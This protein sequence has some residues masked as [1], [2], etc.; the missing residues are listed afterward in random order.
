MIQLVRNAIFTVVIILVLSITIN[1]RTIF[2]HI[3][4]VIS[5]ATK[6]A[7]QTTE[8][9]A[10]AAMNSISR[11]TLDLFDNSVP[12]L[13]DSVKTQLSAPQQLAPA[14]KGYRQPPQ[15]IIQPHERAELDAL[16]KS[17]R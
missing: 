1:G 2:A 16:I 14:S 5:P 10:S 15:E 11:L 3:Y 17:H 9:L 13:R 6:L 8:E 7:Q 4:G 12:K